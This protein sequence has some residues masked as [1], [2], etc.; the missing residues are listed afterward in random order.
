MRGAHAAYATTISV[1]ST[2]TIHMCG[3]SMPRFLHP[4]YC[5]SCSPAPQHVVAGSV[6]PLLKA[7]H[8][9]SFSFS[10]GMCTRCEV[11]HH[12]KSMKAGQQRGNRTAFPSGRCA[13]IRALA[14]VQSAL[15]QP[16]FGHGHSLTMINQ[17]MGSSKR[18]EEQNRTVDVPHSGL[19]I[20]AS[21]FFP[22]PSTLLSTQRPTSTAAVDL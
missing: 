2:R 20:H 11:G 5:F 12:H 1:L 17:R 16:G 18:G 14:E 6:R 13:A 22:V 4:S 8:F 3:Q 19:P 7:S 21:I 15:A 9:S 10:R